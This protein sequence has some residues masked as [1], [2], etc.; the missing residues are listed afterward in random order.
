MGGLVKRKSYRRFC[1]KS[2]C[3]GD[4]KGPFSIPVGGSFSHDVVCSVVLAKGTDIENR[5]LAEPD[6]RISITQKACQTLM[7]TSPDTKHMVFFPEAWLGN[8]QDV[9][10]DSLQ[11]IEKIYGFYPIVGERRAGKY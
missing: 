8:L 1:W 10:G 6:F 9:A 2:C 5:F 3:P 4:F 7:E 11:N